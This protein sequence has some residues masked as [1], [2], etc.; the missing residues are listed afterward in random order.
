MKI[1]AHRGNQL[2]APENSIAAMIS[3]YTSGAQVLEF[4]V[5]L[6]RDNELVVSHD[7]TLNRLT[8]I[9]RPDIFIK[10]LTLKELRWG[11]YDFSTTFDPWLVNGFK[12]NSSAK[13]GQ[14]EKFVDLLD[15]I[16][17]DVIKL[18]ELKHDSSTTVEMRK[19]LVDSFASE[20]KNRGLQKEVCVYSKDKYTLRQLRIFLPEIKIAVFDWQLS[21]IEQLDLLIDEGADGLVTDIESVLDNQNQLTDFGKQLQT[22]FSQNNLKIGAILYPS[23][24]SG[25]ITQS[26]FNF[27]NTQEFVWS[28][29]TDS[30]IGAKVNDEFLHFSDWLYPQYNWLEST[31]FSG[32][33]IDRDWFALGYA[34]NNKYCIISQQDGIQIELKEYDGFLPLPAEVDQI[35]NRLNKA[36]LR[37]MYLEKSWPFYSGGGLAVIKPLAGDFIATV[38]YSF[39]KPIT[40]AQT[41]EMAVT[42]V[43]PAGHRSKPPA[44]F[45]DSDAFYDPHGCP[46]YVGVEH[47]END[48]YRIN[49]NLGAAYDNNQYGSPIGNGNTP[50]S[51]TL[52]LERRGS[53]FSAYYR[54]DHDAPFWICV[55]TIKN[56]SLNGQ[57]FLRCVAKRWLQEDESDSSRFYEVRPNKFTF[58]NLLI[59]KPVRK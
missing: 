47:D 46:P 56:E 31:P 42:N 7:G 11:E 10:D 1:A 27:L 30:M 24:K 43:D 37:L 57:V 40:Q 2:H 9:E 58:R 33:K 36:E 12:Y 20:I 25:V 8:G 28:V 5:Q 14:I 45:R 48:G 41:L 53:Y 38:D 21:A 4:D 29:S 18:I 54:N 32:D 59:T 3:A 15:Q 35:K 51:G 50:Q 44:T 6:T 13:R 23:R 19:A 49:W 55:G 22:L 17:A 39:E 52:R 26:E 16:P 34:K